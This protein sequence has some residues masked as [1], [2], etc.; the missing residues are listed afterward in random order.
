MEHPA[1]IVGREARFAVH[2]TTL[3]SFKAV[4]EGSI[5]LIFESNGTTFQTTE[6]KPTSPGI[7]RPTV[8]FEKSG[9]YSLA[10]ILG[11]PNK[12]T[13][14]VNTIAVYESE[15][16]IP[17]SSEEKSNEQTISFLKEQQWKIDFR[18]EPV[19]KGVITG[20]VPGAGEIIP[21]LNGDIIVSA[22]FA[23]LILPEDNLSVPAPGSY[24]SK[25]QSLATMAPAV[26][27]PDGGEPFAEQYANA[28]NEL[29]VTRQDFERVKKLFDQKL[30]SLKEFEE[31][32]AK[33]KKAEGRLNGIS[34]FV[35]F[36]TGN[37]KNYNF[38]LTSPIEGRIAEV[39]FKIGKQFNA[40]EP[41]FRIVN[42]NRVWLKT[43]VPVTEIGKIGR[44]VNAEFVIPG[45]NSRFEVHQNNGKLISI[46]SVVDEKSRTVP[47]IFEISNPND[48]FRIGMFATVHVK[49]G[50]ADTVLS[51]PETA[52]IEEEGHYALYVHAEGES[53]VKRM[54]ELGERDGKRVGILSGLHEGERVVTVGA[55]QVRLASVSSQLPAHGHEH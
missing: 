20:S 26:Q 11:E 7:Y 42:T 47:L 6:S 36:D 17:E 30:A 29:Y 14:R 10:L 43:A 38:T 51:V 37:Q 15:K 16:D 9:T 8:K 55:Y 31:A 5:T 54:V 13:V 2:L 1:L 52:L 32:E 44:V 34:R 4:S 33:Y 53:F 21:R 28:E 19:Q 41:L 22:P 3:E 46:G 50:R 40:G 27:Q 24:V 35:R 39:N 25:G 23:G 12:D 18:T 45:F 49:T 48:Q